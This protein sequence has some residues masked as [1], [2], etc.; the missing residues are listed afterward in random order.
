MK[1]II[2]F[3]ILIVMTTCALAENI[4]SIAG[5]NDRNIEYKYIQVRNNKNYSS[6]TAEKCDNTNIPILV[7]LNNENGGIGVNAPKNIVTAD[8]YF[9][10]PIDEKGTMGFSALFNLNYPSDYV[11]YIAPATTT[12]LSLKNLL[13][14]AYVYNGNNNTDDMKLCYD[15]SNSFVKEHIAYVKKDEE[16][17]IKDNAGINLN[18]L[19]NLVNRDSDKKADYSFAFLGQRDKNYYN[20]YVDAKEFQIEAKLGVFSSQYV[21][22][23]Q[24]GCYFRYS[25][26]NAYGDQTVQKQLSIQNVIVLRCN[27]DDKNTM[28]L[29]DKKGNAEIFINGKYIEGYWAKDSDKPLALYDNHGNM[30]KLNVGK[31]LISI[32]EYNTAVSILNNK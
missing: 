17:I 28:N 30:L 1:K 16:L 11:S 31:T 2:I 12:G 3:L 4:I 10:Y 32:Q 25:S 6:F 21:W 15:V 19:K 5:Q 24:N 22:D 27:L 18:G 29:Q 8:M 13:S 20:D 9:E 7:E 14:T 26:G 23:K